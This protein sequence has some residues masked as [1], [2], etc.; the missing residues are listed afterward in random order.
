MKKTQAGFPVGLGIP[1]ILM[2]FIVLCLTTLGVLSLTSANSDSKLTDKTE[3]ALLADYQAEQ[4]AEQMLS[5]IDGCLLQAANDT[6]VWQQTG[7]CSKLPV[8]VSARTK[9][10][11]DIYTALVR[12]GLPDMVSLEQDT[13]AFSV[14]L[15][16]GRSLQV[17]VLL[18]NYQESKR[19]EITRYRLVTP[20][21]INEEE[22]QQLWPGTSE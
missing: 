4:I 19:Y 2:I 6:A 13:V 8:D 7:V 5:E 16:D 10:A 12:T 14:P 22:V 15:S 3:A 18:K 21:L 11:Q 20:E 17:S 1:T 9:S